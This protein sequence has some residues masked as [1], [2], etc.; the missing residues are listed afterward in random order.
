[1]IPKPRLRVKKIWLYAS[2]QTFGSE[3]LEKS[4]VRYALIP[5]IAPSRVRDQKTRTEVRKN[6]NGMNILLAS[7]MPLLTPLLQ[8]SQFRNQIIIR[9]TNI[10]ALTWPI[11]NGPLLTERKSLKKKELGSLPQPRLKESTKKLRHHAITT[12]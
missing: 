8:I 10:G 5:S 11:S 6:S 7:S 12:V 3:S 4:G 9:A 2:I 1:M